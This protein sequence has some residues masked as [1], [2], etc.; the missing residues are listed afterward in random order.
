MPERKQNSRVILAPK[1]HQPPKEETA[2]PSCWYRLGAF[3]RTQKY[4]IK[5]TFLLL[6]LRQKL[7]EDC[8][9]F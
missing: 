5:R 7:N 2:Y 6:L 8:D 9:Y 4:L 1:W 3:Y